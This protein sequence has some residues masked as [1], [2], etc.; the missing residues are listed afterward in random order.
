MK[1]NRWLSI[2]NVLAL[3]FTLV[4]NSLANILPINGMNTGQISDLYPSLFTP[5]GITFSIWSVIYLL[6]IAFT[7][8]QLYYYFV[9]PS[10]PRLGWLFAISCLLNSIWIVAWHYL[11]PEL[12]L[13][14][15]LGLLIVLIL[16]F[17]H[18]Q[19]H[20]PETFTEKAFIRLPFTIYLAWICVA[21]I[22]NSAAVLVSYRESFSLGNEEAWTIIMMTIA[23]LL[24]LFITLRYKAPAFAAVV[25]WALIGIFLRWQGSEHSL[26]ATTAALL[27]VVLGSVYIYS[28]QKFL[29]ENLGTRD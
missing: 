21:T 26:L 28:S 29:R 11:L 1:L 17:L 12:A 13:L 9:K 4:M 6:L 25:I 20:P 15:M 18:L 8:Y 2:V 7:I 10:F 23:F 22:A 24:A 14:V 3:I 19:Q 27:F 5:A 16:I